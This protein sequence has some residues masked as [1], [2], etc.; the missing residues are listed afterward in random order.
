MNYKMR[1]RG[2]KDEFVF[3]DSSIGLIRL[4]CFL[5][6][7]VIGI[8]IGLTSISHV[9]RY[10]ITSRP[11]NFYTDYTTAAPAPSYAKTATYDQNVVRIQIAR[12]TI[13]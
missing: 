4:L 9:D 11:D 13:V 1:G 5:I 12:T 3:K 7:F 6:L 10:F 2:E 8:I